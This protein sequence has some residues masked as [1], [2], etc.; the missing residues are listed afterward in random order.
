V[1]DEGLVQK[2][3]ET[4]EEL[5]HPLDRGVFGDGSLQRLH[6]PVRDVALEERAARAALVDMPASY[7]D[8]TPAAQY[9]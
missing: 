4:A 7:S 1:N 3:V 2:H 6:E 8:L 5:V 9:G